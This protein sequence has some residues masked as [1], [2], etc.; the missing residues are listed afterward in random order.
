MI[1][2]FLNKKNSLRIL[3][4]E[5]FEKCLPILATELENVSFYDFYNEKELRDDW[6]K[7]QEWNPTSE[8]FSSTNRI[9]M[10]LCKYFFPNFYNIKNKKGVSFATKWK[11][12]DLK[13]VLKWN[14][15]VHTTP[16]LSEIKRGIYFNYALPKATMFRPQM[17]KLVVSSLNAKRVL[18]P[19][20]GWGGRMLGTVAAG[21]EYVGF[22]TNIETYNGLINLSR[23]LNIENKVKI[24][25]DS[26]LEMEKYD[27]GK[28]DLILTSP[29]YFDLE[30]YSY[31]YAH[32]IKQYDKY[33][34]WVDR[35][36][37]PLINISLLHLKEDGWSCWNVHNIGNMKMI[38]DI[39][40]IHR[41]YSSH[42]IFSIISSKRPTT[43][44]VNLKNSD[45][46][47]CYTTKT[48]HTKNSFW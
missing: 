5:E 39:K 36:L 14:R 13:K 25:N 11:S 12:D 7:L 8:K 29:P 2:R 1:E 45:D 48:I 3:S 35:F 30:I 31:E 37:E 15:K 4:D 20:A 27:I 21:A 23:F 6:A 16:Y 38:D 24:I 26:S 19:C 32:S 46:T 17:A 28:F 9:G 22:E 18:D 47:I 34:Q 40:N 10:K 42:K 44:S 43:K 41:D 33:K